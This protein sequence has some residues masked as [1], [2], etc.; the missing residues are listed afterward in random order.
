L[1]NAILYNMWTAGYKL[2]LSQKMLNSDVYWRKSLLTDVQLI[3]TI[4]LFPS[5]INATRSG[6]D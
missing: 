5:H 1:Q 3:D 4:K 6:A 2:E